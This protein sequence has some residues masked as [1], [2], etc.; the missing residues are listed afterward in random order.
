MLEIS[1]MKP[2]KPKK[3][4]LQNTFIPSGYDSRDYISGRA[5]TGLPAKIDFR[6]DASARL[7][8]QGWSEGC[9]GMATANA[10]DII[11][12]RSGKNETYSPLYLWDRGRYEAGAR[13]NVGIQIRDLLKAATKY[14]VATESEWPFD[15]G[16][17]N[18]LIPDAVT[19][20]AKQRKALRYEFCGAMTDASL[21][22]IKAQLNAGVPVILGLMVS[23]K[24]FNHKGFTGYTGI[25]PMKGWFG[26]AVCI[27]GYDDEAKHLIIENSWGKQFGEDSFFALPYSVYRTDSYEA[28]VITDYDFCKPV[29]VTD[30]SSRG[31]RIYLE[32]DQMFRIT[33]PNCKV[34]GSTAHDS[35]VI[36]RSAT[37]TELDGNIDEVHI[38]WMD[39]PRFRQQGNILEIF[40]ANYSKNGPLICKVPY[41][42][43]PLLLVFAG[44]KQRRVG[45]AGGVTVDGKVVS[46][47]E[48]GA[49]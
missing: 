22:Q 49:I 26:H 16:K 1:K 2:I 4:V 33:S 47:V 7:L 48:P 9:T 24:T 13:G 10:I 6:S 12:R 5:T 32:G 45:F 19:A 31:T 39:D 11:A 29:P 34:Y 8:D 23:D 28:W 18:S 37:D 38:P 27:V 43:K 46:T 17:I 44:N 35:V 14:G 30:V 41:N 42:E 3:K 20:A 21:W 40:D 25:D 36:D 15:L